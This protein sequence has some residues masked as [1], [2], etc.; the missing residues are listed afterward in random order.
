[1]QSAKL[2]GSKPSVSTQQYLDIA[3][4]RDDV[5]IM[6]DGTLRAVLLASSI[7]FALKSE[8]EQNALI[9]AYAS[10]LNTLEYPLQIVIQSRKL[11]MDGYL[12][13]LRQSE[14][15]QTNELLKMQI[16]EYR[17]FI[18]ELVEMGQIM[19]KKFFIVVQ[20]NPL[21]NK[22]KNFF[23]RFKETFM[24]A[25]SVS[26]KREYFLNKRKDLMS[27][28]SAIQGHLQSFGINS[29]VLDTE[30]LVE[31]YYS[32]YNPQ[33][34]DIQKMAETDKLQIE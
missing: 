7:N 5:V 24:P 15:N 8:E 23:T 22:R 1:M 3:S 9:S 31:L 33:L 2:A 14:K 27:R 32:S 12:E 25:F 11:N 16:S 28:L 18:G 26:I 13:K 29:V 21:S 20:Y 30:G 19:S 34:A 6:K 4:I 10:F 17:S